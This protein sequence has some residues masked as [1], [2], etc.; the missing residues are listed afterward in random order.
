MQGAIDLSLIKV[1]EKMIPYDQVMAISFDDE[2]TN[3][4]LSKMIKSG[5]SR[6]PT[7]RGTNRDDVIG[8]F[9]IKKLIGTD[10]SKV[11]KIRELQIPLR[12]PII[13]NPSTSLADLLVEFEKGKSHMAL[14]TDDSE[15]LSKKME[16]SISK[17]VIDAE[18]DPQKNQKKPIQKILGIVTCE[19]L[20]ETILKT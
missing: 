8:I 11:I 1:K 3:E 15:T 7:Y 12:K 2:L 13:L 6:F 10:Y 17:S 16:L 18:E 9:L 20:I 19:D 4:M 5:Y 14:I